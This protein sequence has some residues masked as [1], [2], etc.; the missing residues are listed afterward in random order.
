MS[1]TIT[2]QEVYDYLQNRLL[3]TIG[4]SIGILLTG[5]LISFVSGFMIGEFLQCNELTVVFHSTPEEAKTAARL[6]TFIPNLT[7]V[8]VGAMS[9]GLLVWRCYMVQKLALQSDPRGWHKILWIFPIFLWSLTMSTGCAAASIMLVAI[10]RKALVN[11]GNALQTTALLSNA[12]LNI[13]ATLFIAIRLFNYRRITM[14]LLGSNVDTSRYL[15][16]INILLES[17]AIN[18][19][20]TIAAAV[21]IGLNAFFGAIIAPVAVVGQVTTS[22]LEQMSLFTRSAYDHMQ[23]RLLITIG[24][25]VGILLT[26]GLISSG[27][28]CIFLLSQDKHPDTLKQ[29]RLLRVYIITL[30]LAATAF[31]VE[32]FILSNNL[33]EIFN[34]KSASNIESL[35]LLTFTINITP[36]FVAALTDGLLV[37]RCYM[38]Q[39]LASCHSPKKWHKVF[40]ILPGCFWFITIA[41]GYTAAPLLLL[42]RNRTLLFVATM[43]QTTAFL[44][45]AVLNTYATFFITIRLLKYRKAMMVHADSER[46]AETSR[47]LHIVSIL[48][49]SAAINI[50]ITIAAA[51]GIRLHELF[52]AVIAPVAVAGQALASVIIIHQVAVGRAI[53]AKQQGLAAS[54]R[55]TTAVLLAFVFGKSEHISQQLL[56]M[57]RRSP[58]DYSRSF[59]PPAW[60]ASPQTLDE[61]AG[62]RHPHD[63]SRLVISSTTAQQ[64]IDYPFFTHSH[65]RRRPMSTPSV[66]ELLSPHNLSLPPGPILTTFVQLL[67]PLAF[68]LGTFTLYKLAKFVWRE[69]IS[70]PLADFPGP[71]S[72]SWLY[73]NMRQIWEAENSVMHEGWVQEYGNTIKYKVFVG[74]SRLFTMDLKALNHILMNSQVYQKPEQSRFFLSRLLGDGV[75]VTEGSQHR[76]QNPAFGAAQIRELTEIFVEKSLE[77]RD[78]WAADVQKHAQGEKKQGK[79]NVLTGLS[80]MTLDVI[81]LA[82]EFEFNS[83]SGEKNELN[84]AFNTMFSARPG[85][86]VL[87]VLR[88]MLGRLGVLIPVAGDKAGREARATMDRIGNQLLRDSKSALAE[89]SG[90]KDERFRKRDLL[91][92][93]L[94]ANMSTDVPENQR[95]SD[96]DVLAQVPTFLVAGHETTSNATT[97]ALYALSIRPDIQTKLRDE[98]F[99]IQSDNPTMDELNSLPYL[100][101]V[102][103]ETLRVHA[104]VPSTMR[105]AV[106]DDV[107]PL[108]T[109]FVDKKGNVRDSIL[110]RKGQTLFIPILAINRSE[111][112]WG[113]DARE[114]KPERWESPPEAAS[115]IPGV[116]GNML[117]F[118]GGPRSCIGYRFSLVECNESP[119]VHARTTFEF[120]LAVPA[121]EIGKKSS[122]VQRPILINDPKAGN[123]MPLYVKPYTRVY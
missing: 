39:R 94:K 61:A 120:E 115:A 56:R 101:A 22:F 23:N 111:E 90:E 38:V 91:S 106:E 102:V 107:V 29:H 16:I 92:L 48:L 81:G 1:G 55:I 110:V 49:E 17:A 58:R 20:L 93:L 4:I 33:T 35:R 52:S 89:A 42:T 5:G 69:Y 65:L 73:G 45:N 86:S 44:S 18:V 103:R 30:L 97:W 36:V 113:P 98:L 123:Q 54:T 122:V 53:S 109:P 37:W 66:R 96:E 85:M 62:T 119:L 34:S 104:P 83:L 19:P 112:L 75:L 59:S 80:K 7:P 24:V 99:T 72:P 6:L 21:G 28:A 105:M 78:V 84:E 26:G 41:A 87:L 14:S 27:T 50:P 2:I 47:Y 51:V 95:M 63:S 10:E 71:P 32:E 25:S 46:K 88:G 12:V 13:Y 15:D 43:L 77:L 117:T 76:E 31:I 64:L 3:F 108:A 74:M 70:N 114:F 116:W 79:I 82:G 57:R 121:S 9:D 60:L 8:F 67:T 40:W 118:L 100:D 68:T 11:L